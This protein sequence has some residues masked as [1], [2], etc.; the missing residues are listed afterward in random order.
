MPYQ[1]HDDLRSADPDARIWRFLDF[2][3]FFDLVSS[4]QLNL[5]RSDCFEDRNEGMVPDALLSGVADPRRRTRRNAWHAE[6]RADYYVTCW[7]LSEV[8]PVGMWELYGGADGGV[9]LTSTYLRLRGILDSVQ[10]APCYL[11]VV[12][13]SEGCWDIDRF[14]SD[15]LALMRKRSHFAHEREVRGLVRLNG[16]GGIGR[17]ID[18][19]GRE[20]PMPLFEPISSQNLRINVD[21][22]ALVTGVVMSPRANDQ[23]FL[24]VTEALDR[25]RLK[26]P[27]A[28]SQRVRLKN[29]A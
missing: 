19:E 6:R 17:N 28:I 14:S 20:H 26:V 11:G 9:A 15:I 29:P 1:R 8:E 3:K 25:A 7:H 21:L 27:L 2:D 16:A 22:E 4:R 18:G 12:D 23:W 5:R 24:R 13:Y 10:F